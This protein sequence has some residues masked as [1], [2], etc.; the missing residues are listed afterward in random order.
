MDR[1]A[2]ARALNEIG[3][4]LQIGGGPPFRAKAFIRGAAALQSRAIDL[5]A[6]VREG[7]LEELPGIGPSL[8]GVIEELHRTGGSTLLERLRAEM[9]A[10]VL[11]LSRVLSL[12]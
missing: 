12:A 10:G 5:D 7:R 4:R 9:P 3:R 1:L 11:E 6:L 2:T 8:A